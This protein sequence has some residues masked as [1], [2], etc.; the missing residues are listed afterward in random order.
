MPASRSQQRLLPTQHN[1]RLP[2][3]HLEQTCLLPS[4]KRLHH[5]QPEQLADER[6]CLRLQLLE[7]D[8]QPPAELQVVSSPRVLQSAQLLLPL[9]PPSFLPLL[10]L[11]P[12]MLF[13]S[14]MPAAAAQLQAPGA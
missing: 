9:P 10:L 3:P 12:L 8:A 13:P 14:P 1:L 7:H 2:K 11:Q 6:P 5:P 4:Q